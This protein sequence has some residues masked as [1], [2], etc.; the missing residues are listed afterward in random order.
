MKEAATSSTPKEVVNTITGEQGGEMEAQYV[1]TLPQNLV[2]F[3]C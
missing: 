3:F 2:F 1:S